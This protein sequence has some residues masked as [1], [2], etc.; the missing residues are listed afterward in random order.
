MGVDRR[1]RLHAVIVRPCPALQS[2]PLTAQF[3]DH[4]ALPFPA[5]PFPVTLCHGPVSSPTSADTPFY[6]ETTLP[7]PKM[8]PGVSVCECGRSFL[9]SSA[10]SKHQCTCTKTRKRFSNAW[11]KAREV[12]TQRKKPRLEDAVTPTVVPE[13]TENPSTE[14]R[15]PTMDSNQVCSY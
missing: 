2:L 8:D 10:M 6:W 15:Q 3:F 14:T 4:P 5:T 12:W 9:Q 13:V 7:R 1:Y 11:T